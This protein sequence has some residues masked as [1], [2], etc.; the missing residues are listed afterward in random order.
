MEKI[1]NKLKIID[2]YIIRKFLGTFFYA[3]SL[4][5]IIIIIFDIAEKI[6]DFIERDAPLR[7]I[8]FDYYLNFLPYFINL[9]SALFTFIAVIFFTSRMAANTEIIA[10]LN[11]GISFWRLMRPYIISALLLAFLS[12]YLANF[13]IPIT[14]R[15]MIEFETKYIKSQYKAA[16]MNIHMQISP[17]TF[18]YVE[19][20]NKE[21]HVGYR[22][23][24]EKMDAKGLSY[25]LTADYVTWDSIKQQWKADMWVERT[26]KEMHETLTHGR[27]KNI[28][29]PLVP[30]DFSINVDDTK[31]MNYWEL[32]K[33]ISR[34]KMR[35]S[36]TVAKFEVEKYKRIAWPFATIVLTII[37]VALS[38]RKV[39]GGT[40]LNLG[41]GLS[42]SFAFIL[43]MQ[44]FTVFATFG[45]LPPIIAV[46]I[47]NV[48]FGVLGLYLLRMT[49]K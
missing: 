6:D 29:I 32:R 9:F 40:G 38:S 7:A 45:N 27:T 23:S 43:F 48:L 22:F 15:K 39:R 16:D 5:A 47:P 4:L 28:K 18:I 26:I 49:P 42:I 33:F 44:F 20:Y 14:N 17:G 34:E 24:L 25:K 12:F 1:K 8:I 41:L 46:W 37:G 2:V 10:I 30:K 11:S 36:A 19:S 3:I 35:G 31:V 21:A 13:L